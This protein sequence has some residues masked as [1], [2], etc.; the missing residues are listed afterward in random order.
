MHYRT[1]P[2]RTTIEG[3]IVNEDNVEIAIEWL[4]TKITDEFN[5]ELEDILT[6]EDVTNK[7][8]E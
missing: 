1:L 8:I 6:R 4:K 3:A 5:N 7:N 2:I